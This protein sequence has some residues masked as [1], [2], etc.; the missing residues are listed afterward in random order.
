MVAFYFKIII[1][2]NNFQLAMTQNTD[3]AWEI[4]KLCH[5]DITEEYISPYKK[6]VI[7]TTKNKLNISCKYDWVII[8]LRIPE[9]TVSIGIEFECHLSSGPKSIDLFEKELKNNKF[10]IWR[11]WDDSKCI[12][13]HLER[14]KESEKLS[15]E[16]KNILVKY[17]IPKPTAH[18]MSKYYHSD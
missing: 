11:F 5:P 12:S 8:S 10:R 7:I 1:M 13:D 4:V 18:Q 14:S 6:E 16:L 17:K 15:D 3:V 9:I 2:R